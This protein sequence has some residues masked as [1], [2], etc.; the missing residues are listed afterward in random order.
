MSAQSSHPS[1]GTPASGPGPGPAAARRPAAIHL[2]ACGVPLSLIM[3]LAAPG[4]PRSQEILTVEG[5][6]KDPWW[7]PH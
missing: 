5:C 7:D 4:G 3:D 2:L 1:P 6:P